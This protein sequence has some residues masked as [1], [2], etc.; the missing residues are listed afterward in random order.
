[1]SH[2]EAIEHV[3]SK[4]Y[5]IEGK[6]LTIFEKIKIE[7]LHEFVIR[8]YSYLDN[9]GGNSLD[10]SYIEIIRPE[11]FLNDVGMYMLVEHFKRS[12]Q[13]KNIK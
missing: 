2:E 7:V 5:K 11:Y 8:L 13:S 1:M 9:Y 12:V 3:L 4:V 10:N 6:D